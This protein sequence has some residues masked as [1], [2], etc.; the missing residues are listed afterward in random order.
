MSRLCR[1]KP[2]AITLVILTALFLLAWGGWLDF[3]FWAAE[4]ARPNPH[5]L[6][7]SP[8]EKTVPSSLPDRDASVGDFLFQSVILSE[9][10]NPI[11][12]PKDPA[13]S[14]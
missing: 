11:T 3:E 10:K 2:A 14:D 6:G 13:T 1:L 4:R 5:Y 7:T 9:A 12:L 8:D